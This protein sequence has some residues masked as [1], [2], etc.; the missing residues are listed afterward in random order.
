MV[1][2]G[3]YRLGR[4]LGRGGMAV[5]YGGIDDRLDRQVAVKVLR[6]ELAADA[7][8]RSRFETEARSAA[9]LVHPN[10]V[11][12]FDTGESGGRPYIVMEQLS[13]ETLADRIRAAPLAEAAAASVGAEVLAALAMAHAAG[14]IHRD[15]K[16]ANILVCRDG[17]V[18]VA[19]FGIAKGLEPQPG[20]P[21][22][23]TATA[24]LIGTPAYLAPERLAGQPATVRSDL[25]SVGV[26]LYEAL[27]GTKPFGGATPLAVAGAI[28]H[29]DPVPLAQHRPDLGR[30]VLGTVTRALA[31]QPEDRF[32]SANQMADAL[33]GRIS[34]GAAPGSAGVPGLVDPTV[35][36][37]AYQ[38][39]SL[40]PGA[41][42]PA[43]G[44]GPAVLGTAAT[45]EDGP[46]GPPRRGPRSGQGRRSRAL[47]LAVLVLALLGAVVAIALQPSSTGRSPVP[48]SPPSTT[49]LVNPTTLA[50]TTRPP[51]TT[52]PL[53]TT[54]LPTTT[55]LAPTTAATTG[56]MT[57]PPPA[58]RGG[59]GDQ[60]PGSGK[61]G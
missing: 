57:V 19:D 27:A 55:T 9:R 14:I 18:K 26:V 30:A 53:P 8:L 15:V 59:H 25:W 1:L 44:L 54:T 61:G 58:G 34:A 46:P 47:L 6:A 20:E 42:G 36:D 35:A 11:S 7:G 49:N 4:V 51:P 3:R 45:A 37:P 32:E 40:L 21:T 38:A 52:R 33:A 24:M 17:S 23:L 22:D 48:S 16:P 56:P 28:Q 43:G 2:A 13:G 50:P 12:V 60:G 5:V 41:A 31:R 29:T 39:T 10:V